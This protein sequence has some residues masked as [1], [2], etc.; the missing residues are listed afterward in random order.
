MKII[1]KLITP[2]SLQKKLI[3][4]QKSLAN[5]HFGKE[6]ATPETSTFAIRK[7]MIST[8]GQSLLLSVLLLFH[9]L[10]STGLA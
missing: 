1:G 10:F 6:A 3:L 8:F 4:P 5:L 2:V 9:L 7:T